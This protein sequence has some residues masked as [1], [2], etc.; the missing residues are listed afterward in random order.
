MALATY[1][2]TNPLSDYQ[3]INTK[4]IQTIANSNSIQ[5]NHDTEIHN[6]QKIL[7][8]PQS[9]IKNTLHNQN[10]L[11]GYAAETRNSIVDKNSNSLEIDTKLLY[12]VVGCHGF[13]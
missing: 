5:L 13:Y 11:I 4:P 8:D 10:I 3:K 9:D 1:S 2:N 12:I 6:N 7:F